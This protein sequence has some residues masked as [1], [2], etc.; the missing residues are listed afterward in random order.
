MTLEDEWELIW[1]RTMSAAS[2]LFLANRATV[3]IYVINE[4]MSYA[5]SKVTAH[6]IVPHDVHTHN[7]RLDV[8]CPLLTTFVTLTT[9]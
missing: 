5:S 1:R 9:I 2:W 7:R 8:R 3:G 6:L 4:V